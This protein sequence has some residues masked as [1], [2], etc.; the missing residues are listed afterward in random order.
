MSLFNT[1]CVSYEFLKVSYS[2][3]FTPT[4]TFREIIIYKEILGTKQYILSLAREPNRLLIILCCLDNS[5][6]YYHSEQ[7]RK[8]H[9]EALQTTPNHFCSQLFITQF[10]LL[11]P[12]P[13]S[14]LARTVTNTNCCTQYI[15]TAP[16]AQHV[17]HM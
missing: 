3:L 14:L 5:N 16:S 6:V 12:L 1:N 4:A 9:L 11:P 2:P 15:P 8:Y 10:P 7:C 17:L 13:H